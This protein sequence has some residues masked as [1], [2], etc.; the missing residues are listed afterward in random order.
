[1]KRYYFFFFSAILLSGLFSFSFSLPL[2]GQNIPVQRPAVSLQRIVIGL[3]NGATVAQLDQILRSEKCFLPADERNLLAGGRFMLGWLDPVSADIPQSDAALYDLLERLQRHSEIAFAQPFLLSPNGALFGVTDEVL[4]KLRTS[5]DLPRLKEIARR[6]GAE[7]GTENSYLPRVYTLRVKG[8]SPT[9][10][11]SLAV[12]LRDQNVFEYVDLN[13]LFNPIVATNDPNFI[14]QWSL[15]NTG[16]PIQG[17]G[18]PGADMSVVDA[19]TVTTGNPNIK[20]AIIDSGTDTTHPDLVD[21]LLP[22]HDASGGSSEGYPN[23]NYAEDAHGTNCAGIAGAKGENNIG[24]AGVCYD[25]NIVPIKVFYYINNPFGD[26]LPFSQG[27]AMA[28]AIS[29]AWQVAGAEVLSNSWGIPDNLIPILPGGSA[30]VVDAIEMA[31]DSGRGGKGAMLF[32]S[33]GNDGGKPIWPG[34]LAGCFSVNATTMCDERKFPGSCDGQ[35]W[36]GNWGD[37]LDVSAPGVRVAST[38]MV[39][40]NGYDSGDYN[41]TFGGTSAACPNAAGVMGLMLSVNPN[42]SLGQAHQILESTCERVGGYSYTGTGPSGTWSDELGYG[43][44][45]AHAAVMAAQT[46]TSTENAGSPVS[47]EAIG[48]QISPNPAQDHFTFEYSLDRAADVS[49]EL[50]DLHGKILQTGK[51]GQLSV[52]SYRQQILDFGFFGRSGILFLTLNIS[53]HKF[54]K[55]VLI[56]K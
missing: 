4:I 9:D 13:Y 33:S 49:W 15:E 55:K 11:I 3:E 1:M 45:N 12:W 35:N 32:F 27:T 31:L 52:G 2:Q 39:G 23:T 43:R 37:S 51:S 20:I 8:D 46:V 47:T 42:L 36:E 7:V 44:I 41:L 48:F 22:G 10:P 26:P 53:G 25:C 5:H 30:I 21:N 28:E 38:D 40:G 14:W 50:R 54:T 34:R 16:S 19:W 29:W 18:T 56:I 17:N 24:V 6:V